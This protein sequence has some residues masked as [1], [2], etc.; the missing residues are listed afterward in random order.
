MPGHE[1][2]ARRRVTGPVGYGFA[3]AM[4]LIGLVVLNTHETW[5]PLLGGVVTARFPEILWAANLSV[6]VQLVGNAL[7]VVRAPPALRRV[8]EFVFAVLGLVSVSVTLSVFPFD[9]GR[10]GTWSNVVARGI[11]LVGVV[12]SAVGV[13]VS[14]V[15]LGGLLRSEVPWKP[16]TRPAGEVLHARVVYESIFG[17]TRD[18]ALAVARGLRRRPEVEVEVVEVGQAGAAAAPCDLLVVGAPVHAWSMTRGATREGARQQAAQ[19]GVE[20]VSRGI[21]IREYLDG[22][23][24]TE[25]VAAAAFDTAGKTRWF[26]VG[27]AARPEARRLVEHGYQVIA[28]PEHFYVTDVKGPLLAGEVA[29]AEDWGAALV[30]AATGSRQAA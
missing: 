24:D 12:G 5:R 3:A 9:L 2:P 7:L 16:A 10:F 26:P 14:L 23:P 20:P 8:L 28:K 17:N 30:E 4:N 21:G 19:A 13:L 15:R 18:I 29:R 25:G 27:S 6:A 1:S 11:L 22:L